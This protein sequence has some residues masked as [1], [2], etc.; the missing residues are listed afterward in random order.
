MRIALLFALCACGSVSETR[1]D[2]RTADSCVPESDTELCARATACE[3]HSAMD[4]CGVA[5]TVNCGDCTGGKGCVVG[6]C[7]TPV[8]SSFTYMRAAFPAFTQTNIEDSMGGA[9]P[10]GKTILYIKTMGASCGAFRLIVADETTTGTYSQQDV[11]TNL[12]ASGLFVGQDGY[13]ITA[14]G[15]T[16][17]TTTNRKQL[18]SIKRSAVGAIDFGAPSMTDFAAINATI[19]A[20]DP[21][22]IFA[23]NIS[24][25]GLELFYTVGGFAAADAMKNGIFN[26]V[27]TSTSV[28][29]PAP[30]RMPAPVNDPANGP[31]TG[32][33]SDRLAVFVFYGYQTRIFTRTSTS[34]PFENPNAGGNPPQ[35]EGWSHKPLAD[36]ATLVGM[37][38]PGGCA[39]EDVVKMNR[40]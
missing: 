14:D 39:N 30:T 12:T 6:V 29:F 35:I 27:R 31:L 7:K 20:S 36:C 33:S 13:A 5:R 19:T 10:D 3:M 40:Q 4:N 22:Q 17:I 38:S 34:K 11:S 18:A 32:V 26:S 8:C 24:A 25:D 16:I 28:P 21:G 9:T 15:L 23:P 2:G 1:V 37:Y